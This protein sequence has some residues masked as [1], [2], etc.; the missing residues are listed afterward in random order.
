MSEVNPDESI[1]K[2]L[3]QTHPLTESE[4]TIDEY[5]FRTQMIEDFR[6]LK[7]SQEVW[8]PVEHSFRRKG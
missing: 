4:R 2:V 3:N 1:R 6:Y 8:E 7:I 5:E